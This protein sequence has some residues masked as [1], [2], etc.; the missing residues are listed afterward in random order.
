PAGEAVDRQALVVLDRAG[1][2]RDGRGPGQLFHRAQPRDAGARRGRS[3][4]GGP[5][6]VN[7]VLVTLAFWLMTSTAWAQFGFVDTPRSRQERVARQLTPVAIALH[8]G[9]PAAQLPRQ[10]DP[11]SE[12]GFAATTDLRTIRVRVHAAP[13]YHSVGAR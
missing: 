11:N 1:G 4:M 5:G 3:P 6:A 8:S 9:P 12:R 2:G 10:R 13:D 7:R